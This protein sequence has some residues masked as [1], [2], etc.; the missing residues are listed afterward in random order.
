MGPPGV[1]GVGVGAGFGVPT[2]V[3]VGI[4]VGVGV[5]FGVG[6]GV[7]FGVGVAFGVGVGVGFGPFGP[8]VVAVT[9]FE[10]GESKMPPPGTG[11]LK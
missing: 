9:I 5:A 3:G 7:I 4:G 11:V 6:V 2:G 1:V 8:Q 10:A